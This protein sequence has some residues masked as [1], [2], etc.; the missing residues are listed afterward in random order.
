MDISELATFSFAK[1]ARKLTLS[2]YLILVLIGRLRGSKVH[3]CQTRLH[4]RSD[5]GVSA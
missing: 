3:D 4:A 5:C 2:K 1:L